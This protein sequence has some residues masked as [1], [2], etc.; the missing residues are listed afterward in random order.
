MP[1]SLTSC[2]PLSSLR[3]AWRAPRV[4]YLPVWRVHRSFVDSRR[5][6]SRVTAF[7]FA[8]PILNSFIRTPLSLRQYPSHVGQ[9]SFLA[10]SAV[11]VTRF[12]RRLGITRRI[13][14]YRRETG[15]HIRQHVA[16]TTQS[17]WHL[18]LR[19]AIHFLL[20]G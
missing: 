10:Q 11:R 15:Y 13:A 20:K 14:R 4:R 8:P 12:P 1:S 9:L 6:Q 2:L 19:H 17:A 16:I 18:E 7:L 5:S 3:G